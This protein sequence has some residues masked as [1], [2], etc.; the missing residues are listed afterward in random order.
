MTEA[1]N[2]RR[3]PADARGTYEVWYTTWNDPETD[4]GFWLR[5][6]TE[7]PVDGAPR[8]ELWFARFDPKRPDKT[9]GIHK[10]FPTVRSGEQPFA[11]EIGGAR[12]GHDHA[13]GTLDG[14][15]H[16]IRW[17]LRWEPASRTLRH[18]PDVM[19]LKG[20]LGETSVHSPNPRV[21][22]SGT[23]VV[24]GE[25]LAFHRAVAGQ[26]HVWGKKH[27]YSWTW[28]RCADFPDAPDAVLELLGVRLA[29]RGVLLPPMTLV[30]LDL[31]GERY[32]FNQFRHVVRNRSTWGTARAT[33]AAWS[34][35]VRIEGELACAPDQMV[36]APYLDPD[37]TE[38]FCCNTEIGDAHV[39]L[40]KRRGLGWRE[41]RRLEAP[42]RA[43]F[44]IGG[45]VRDPEV[46][47]P[48][49]LVP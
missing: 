2:H 8:G 32:R 49:V 29:R 40:W 39:T 21:P 47:R 45:R 19:Y 5:Y 18:L 10:R 33:F 12:L 28:G 22:L 17:D 42:R 23:L 24:D 6:I 31:D 46:T 13:V 16:T 14:D 15:G 34:P 38:V 27:A 4:Q 36:Q 20:G 48:H 9:F 11:I 41:V 26:T 3:W 43:H 25:T 37:G 7:N 1:D 35:T 44:E 30:A